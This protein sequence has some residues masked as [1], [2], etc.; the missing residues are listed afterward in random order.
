MF[1]TCTR[2]ILVFLF[3]ASPL[4]A[5]AVGECPGS[6]VPCGCDGPD[7]NTTV[8]SAEQC[9]FDHLIVLAQN[10]INFLI[11]KI[12]A[13]LAAVMFAYAGFLYL[14]NRGNESQVKQA[15]D[16]FTYVLIGLVLALAAWLIVNL[17]VTFF[18]D[19]SY[20]FLSP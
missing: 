6:L 1:M 19:P 9:T 8:D 5:A 3:I 16:V 7:A 18:L 2:S 11:F 14:T 15:H 4:F 10:V 17:I 12:A 20:I 13:P